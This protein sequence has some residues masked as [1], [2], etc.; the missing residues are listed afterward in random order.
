MRCPECTIRNS[1]AARECK[2]CGLKFKKKESPATFKLAIGGVAAGVV[3]WGIGAAIMP[4]FSDPGHSLSRTAKQVAAGPK[5]PEEAL[6]MRKDL[7]A[8]VRNYLQQNGRLQTK[9][10]TAKLQSELSSSA[11]EVHGFDLPRGLKLIE[12]DTVLNACDY[13]VINDQNSLKVQVLPGMEVFDNAK[14]IS[15]HGAPVLVLIGHTAGTGARRPLIQALALLPGDVADETGKAVPGLPC[16]GSAQFAANNRD[17][18]VDMSLFSAGVGTELFKATPGV[19]ARTDDETVRCILKWRNGHYVVEPTL[20][21]GPLSPITALCWGM[22]SAQTAKL[23]SAYLGES[24]QA[25][26]KANPM[27]G[28]PLRFAVQQLDSGKK[29]GTLAYF[30]NG[31]TGPYQVDLKQENGKWIFWGAKKLTSSE[32]VIAEQKSRVPE[33]KNPAAVPAPIV[34]AST[35]SKPK[36]AKETTQ[37]ASAVVPAVAPVVVAPSKVAAE[38]PT[39]PARQASPVVQLAPAAARTARTVDP[40]VDTGVQPVATNT[41]KADK[42][43]EVAKVTS[44]TSAKSASNSNSNTSVKP[45]SIASTS[46]AKSVVVSTASGASTKSATASTA[47]VSASKSTPGN[48]SGQPAK[49]TTATVA[50]S[51][52]KSVT[53]NVPSSQAKSPSVNVSAAPGKSGTNTA[54]VVASTATKSTTS[55]SKTAMKLPPSAPPKQLE[56]G[57]VVPKP[58]EATTHSVASGAPTP[59]T[60]PAETVPSKSATTASKPTATAI[61]TTSSQ[62]KNTAVAQSN[63]QIALATPTSK[64]A[65]TAPPVS[66]GP[67][68]LQVSDADSVKVRS[69]PATDY[70]T[71][72]EVPKG[73]KLQVLGQQNGWYKVKVNNKEGFVYGGLVDYKKADA[74]TTAVVKRV[75][76]VKD[77]KQNAVAAPKTGDKLVVLSG[78]QDGKYKVQLANGKIGYVN[79]DAIDVKVDAPQLVP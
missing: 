53:A 18:L 19:I 31:S 69:G 44:S 60:R 73:S 37:I 8:A 49:S 65:V 74:Y 32:A 56:F 42:V 10:L 9:E 36:K 52:A 17:I 57:I 72:T 21:R 70:R 35:S 59:G 25:F 76:S 75:E 2:Q 62:T 43:S 33:F 64:P 68:T 4:L 50:A 6:R 7:D 34:V 27:N 39:A 67:E 45:A 14:L 20:G 63:K 38:V 41:K 79:K 16:E 5:T 11:Y 30:L 1:V 26:A 54:S 13:L 66:K 51:P 22:R 29:Q 77:T 78:I 12:V 58:S 28:K 47:L 15:E 46:A 40:L 55:T 71:L 61:S 48:V 23:F 24:G 3:L